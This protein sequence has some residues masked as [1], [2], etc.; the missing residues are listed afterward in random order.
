MGEN[1]DIGTSY[2]VDMYGTGTLRVRGATLAELFGTD[3][4]ALIA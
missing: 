1:C 2:A 4:Q 3:D